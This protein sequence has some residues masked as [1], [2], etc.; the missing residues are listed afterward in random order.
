LRRRRSGGTGGEL[1][2]AAGEKAV[3]AAI[4]ALG[5]GSG[6]SRRAVA[7][8]A[9]CS[10]VVGVDD[11]GCV[12]TGVAQ[13]S[14]LA[15]DISSLAIQ[16]AADCRRKTRRNGR[17]RGG[18]DRG[19]RHSKGACNESKDGSGVLHCDGKVG[20]MRDGTVR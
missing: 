3:D 2:L 14:S 20:A 15:H 8:V 17:S 1:G 9:L 13:A 5:V 6:S 11:L 19:L 18:R 7:L 4:N 10:A 12:G 16:R